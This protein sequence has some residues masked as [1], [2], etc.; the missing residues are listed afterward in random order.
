M[1]G[2]DEPNISILFAWYFTR[3]HERRRAQA[4]S[5]VSHTEEH[6]DSD[7]AS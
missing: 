2:F 6:Y 7:D 1:N 4:A 5:D 3:R